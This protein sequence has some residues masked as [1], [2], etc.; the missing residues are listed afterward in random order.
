MSPMAVSIATALKPGFA[1]ITIS[2]QLTTLTTHSVSRLLKTR[3]TRRG[4]RR[5]PVNRRKAFVS[6]NGLNRSPLHGAFEHLLDLL[7]LLPRIPARIKIYF[8]FKQPRPRTGTAGLAAGTSCATSCATRSPL[9]VRN[10]SSPFS[11]DS[12]SLDRV[13]LAS[14][15]PTS[16]S[17]L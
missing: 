13:L 5:P 1:F 11:G 14:R 6:S 15:I 12:T 3:S 16:I 4:S 9:F 2:Q 17:L 7:V 8:F 10:T